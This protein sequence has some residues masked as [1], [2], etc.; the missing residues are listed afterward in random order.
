M[1]HEMNRAQQAIDFALQGKKVAVVSGGDAGIYGMAG[2]VLELLD[3][4]SS[5]AIPVEIIPGISALNSAAA[6]L[7]APLMNI[8]LLSSH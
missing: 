5:D 1:R 4:L 7:G 6:L 8:S 3:E 2:I